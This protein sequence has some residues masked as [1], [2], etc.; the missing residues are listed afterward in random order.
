MW[1]VPWDEQLV[2]WTAA[3]MAGSWAVSMV[4]SLAGNWAVQMAATKVPQRAESKAATMAESMAA[5]WVHQ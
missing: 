4:A 2:E 3:T 5:L 1:A